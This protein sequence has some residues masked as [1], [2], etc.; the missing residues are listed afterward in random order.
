VGASSIHRVVTVDKSLISG[1]TVFSGQSDAARQVH[2]ARPRDFH[3]GILP[4]RI[5]LPDTGGI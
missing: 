5:D 4:K 2:A 3:D 1:A